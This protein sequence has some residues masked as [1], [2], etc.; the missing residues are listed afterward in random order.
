MSRRRRTLIFGSA[1]AVAIALL[2]GG[3]AIVHG[4]HGG[5]VADP[6]DYGPL[7]S[8]EY[9]VALRLARAEIARQD[10]PVSSATATVWPG[11]VQQH[12]LAG[13]CTSGLVLEVDLVGRFPHTGV[14]PDPNATGPDMKLVYKADARTGE[15]CDVSVSLGRFTPDPH[16]ANLLPALS[17]S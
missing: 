1:V 17:A 2:T 12:N 8:T 5:S 13:T 14:S 10:A 11:T 16:A 4:R 7:T 9:A 6:S 15:A 3:V